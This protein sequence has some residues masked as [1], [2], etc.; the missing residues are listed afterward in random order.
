[1]GAIERREALELKLSR[2]INL[3]EERLF[4]LTK[5]ARSERFL[6]GAKSSDS[7]RRLFL[8]ADRIKKNLKNHHV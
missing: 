5:T 4:T 2:L 1:M 7:L 6:Q 3:I 8:E